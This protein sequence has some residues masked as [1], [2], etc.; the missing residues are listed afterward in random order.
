MRKHRY[1][2]NV[3]H[4]WKVVDTARVEEHLRVICSTTGERLSLFRSWEIRL[5]FHSAQESSQS[6]C[7]ELVIPKLVEAFLPKTQRK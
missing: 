5:L 4:T 1:C 3:K 7:A 6:R 2:C